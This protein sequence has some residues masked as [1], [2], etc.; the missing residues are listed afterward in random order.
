MSIGS[1]QRVLEP[2]ALGSVGSGLDSGSV[3]RA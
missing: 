1:A 2:Q 3:Y